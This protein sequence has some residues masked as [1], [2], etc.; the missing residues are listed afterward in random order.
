MRQK[1]VRKSYSQYEL[2]YIL[3]FSYSKIKEGAIELEYILTFSYSKIKEGAIAFKNSSKLFIR[4]SPFIDIKLSK[5]AKDTII[6]S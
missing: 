1:K 6:I 5:Y 2:E 4:Y 3:T